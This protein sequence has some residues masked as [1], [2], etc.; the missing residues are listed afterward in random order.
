MELT[1]HLIPKAT[2]DDILS[3]S[4]LLAASDYQNI[5]LL[6]RKGSGQGHIVRLSIATQL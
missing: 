3:F 1:G 2:L 4:L 6:C 5:P